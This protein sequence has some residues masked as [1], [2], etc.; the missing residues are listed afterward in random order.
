MSLIWLHGLMRRKGRLKPVPLKNVSV[1]SPCPLR[2]EQ[3]IGNERVRHCS[4][5]NL[6]VYNSRR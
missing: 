6:N 1:A 3:M 2:W 5:C 4:E